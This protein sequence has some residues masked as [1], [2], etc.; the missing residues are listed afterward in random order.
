MWPWCRVQSDDA[1]RRSRC[2]LRCVLSRKVSATAERVHVLRQSVGVAEAKAS[3]RSG[4]RWRQWGVR[5][6]AA[7][8]AD[9]KAGSYPWCFP[10]IGL[11]C[12]KTFDDATLS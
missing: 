3:G 7:G 12:S 8:D 10:Q 11:L 4:W 6:I 5:P 9:R 1:W 2:C